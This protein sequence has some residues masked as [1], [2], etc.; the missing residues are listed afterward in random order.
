LDWRQY[1]LE[2]H[3]PG[4]ERWVF[5]GLEEATERRT[6]RA[7]HRDLLE[8]FDAAVHAHRERVAFRRLSGEREE[9]FTY[10]E[11]H[12][13]A[14][15]VG[16]F[17]LRCGVKT[18]DRVML[19]S[20][21]RPEWG[22]SYFGILR[23]GATAVPVDP[24]LSSAEV[25]NVARRSGAVVCLISEE[26]AHSLPGLFRALAEAGVETQVH[27]LAQAMAG[28][29]A[30][31][32][33]I[34]PVRRSAP[35]DAVAS[36]LFTSGTTGQPK[37]VMLTHRNFTALVAKLAGAFDLQV[38]DGVLSV[39]PL[40][41]TFEFSCGFL[42][43][44]S[45][46]AE[47]TY[48]DE[49]NSDRLGQALEG[50]RI[51]AM[52][53]VPALWQLMHKKVTQE[54]AARPAW[55][56]HGVKA[57]M[58]AH[59]ELRDRAN[60]NLGKLL[61]WPVH[62]KFGGHLKFLVSGG[63]ALAPEVA[64]AFHAFGFTLSEGYGLTEAAPVLAVGELAQGKPSG[65][66]GKP[67][68][69]IDLRILDPNVDGVGEVL[70]KGPNVMAGYFQDAEATAAVLKDGWLHTGDLG[71]LDGEG[72]L[73]LAGRKKDVI[74]DAN[75][76]NVFPDELEPLYARHDWVKEVSV[77]GLPDASGGEKVACLCVPDYADRPR[78]EV[79]RA[80]EEH[81][82]Q[83]SA[84]LPFYRRVKV[85]RFSELELP[86]TPTR[87]VKRSLVL[88]ELLRQERLDSA[89]EKAL[90]TADRPGA[91]R[92]WLEDL[93]AEVC[94]KPATQ[95]GPETRLVA[96]LGFDSL[97][98]A[99]LGAAL[100]RAGVSVPALGD[101]TRVETVADL[102]ALLAVGG[103]GS[104]PVPGREPS[105]APRDGDGEIPV[106]APVARAG[107]ALLAWGQRALYG[108]V[109]GV[110]VSGKS[111]IPQNRNFLVVSNHA[112]HLD[113]GLIKVVLGDQGE[114][115]VAL[116]ARDYFFDTPL[117]RAYFENFTHLIPMDRNG[118]LRESLRLA[119][120]ALQ[121]GHNLLIFPEGTRSPTGELLEF[122]STLGYLAMTYGMDVLPLYLD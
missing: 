67:L 51:S 55:V 110:K 107:R 93:V 33:R 2:V 101:L 70:A 13:Y 68:P 14:A 97:L 120:E 59:G 53:G 10:G 82:R 54:L 9:R 79:R 27:S 28:D 63:S 74:I 47:V 61:F 12:R 36:L 94:Q 72:R 87:K 111:F 25:V 37:G 92:D 114:R 77:V 35:A 43:P 49:L 17:L 3:L 84:A 46:G 29:D 39:L 30:Y 45:L 112:S 95:V 108:G 104:G 41:H 86:K 19:A 20:E 22:M 96:D 78:D 100:E 34:A 90:R 44:F 69:G 98:L 57:L 91:Q 66:V 105:A 48:L 8:L 15:R 24:E 75:G 121:Q 88:Q 56:E 103:K 113:M 31:P 83:V 89:R 71:R 52:V 106:P 109:F 32:D 7:A 18:G 62:R 119:G 81:F 102:R 16:S 50:G 5:P 122:K 73:H 117:K 38:G 6:S 80:L 11:V 1:F 65:T 21:N 42:T 85:L 26:A 4:L 115:L 99:E 60:V 116:A 64:E 118:S 58:A 40:H 76:K 23:A